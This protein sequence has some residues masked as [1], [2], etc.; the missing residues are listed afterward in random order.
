MTRMTDIFFHPTLT[1][2]QPEDGI[3]VEEEQNN[4]DSILNHYKKLIAMRNQHTA[5]YHGTYEK[6]ETGTEGLYGYKVTDGANQYLVIHNQ[7]AG[8]KTI[9]LNV[10]G[11]DIY[12]DTEITERS[13]VIKAYSSFIMQYDSENNPIEVYK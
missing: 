8:D 7:G 5:F 10:S 11:R 12:N 1:Y 3:S 2:V 9:T 4:Q 6:L 13:V